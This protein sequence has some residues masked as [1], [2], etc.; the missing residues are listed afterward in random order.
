[1]VFATERGERKFPF[2]SAS[3]PRLP[4]AGAKRSKITR[5]APRSAEPWRY[6][7]KWRT[8]G[9]KRRGG[10]D[11]RRP[12]RGRGEEAKQRKKIDSHGRSRAHHPFKHA[13]PVQRALRGMDLR[14]VSC[15]AAGTASPLSTAHSWRLRR[16][17]R[18]LR[19][20]RPLRSTDPRRESRPA[21]ATT[22]P[23]ASTPTAAT[24]PHPF[25]NPSQRRRGERRRGRDSRPA[26]ATATTPASASA[27]AMNPLLS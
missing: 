21:T 25:S 11:S 26:A 5:P 24:H 23:P 19:D 1:M 20:E 6:G 12:G 13:L 18:R 7:E 16:V 2:S 15:P 4:A 10:F 14:R 27:E 8:T 3:Q 17:E 9:S 22:T